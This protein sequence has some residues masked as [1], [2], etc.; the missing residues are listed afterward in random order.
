MKK[1]RPYSQV[2]YKK[3]FAGDIRKNA[4][5]IAL[6][7]RKFEIDLY[8]KRATEK[9]GQ[10]AISSNISNNWSLTPIMHF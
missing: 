8:W 3:T 2:E 1:T 9:Q 10:R 6:D 5:E 4:L 7:V